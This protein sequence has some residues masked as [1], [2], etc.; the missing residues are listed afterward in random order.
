MFSREKLVTLIKEGRPLPEIIRVA[1]K[2]IIDEALVIEAQRF[3]DEHQESL[4]DGRSR[5]V[6]NGTANE[7]QILFPFGSVPVKAPRIL[8]RKAGEDGLKFTSKALPRYLRKS[9]DLVELIPWLYLKGLS[10]NDFKSVFEAIYGQPVHGFSPA[11][12]SGHVEGWVKE[13]VAW[14]S[15]DMTRETYAYV[16]ADGVYFKV[17]G[18]RDNVCQLVLLGVDARGCKRLVGMAEGYAESSDSW[19]EL[20]VK[21][22]SQGLEGP[23]LV[24]GDGG[25]GL[26]SALS[27][28]YPDSAKQFCWAHK[29]K[30]VQRYLPK[31]RHREVIREV[32]DIYLSEKKE[33][34]T[35]KI[36]RLGAMFEVKHVQAAETLTRHI[37][38]L[39]AFYDF[40]SRHWIHIRTNNPIESLFSTVRLRTGKTRGSLGRERLGALVFKLGQM[41]SA[42]MRAITH[43]QMLEALLSGRK[44]KDGLELEE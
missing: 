13:Y 26:W 39:L 38:E 15:R 40:P 12:I 4:E 32:R 6:L 14:S 23:K 43:A 44:Y 35:K 37:E 7:R 34:A 33:E 28:V 17:K 11:T 9:Q 31:S 30:D 19:R 41:A 36:K 1:T 24:V 42:N 27:R 5:L 2:D 22:K 16:W 8:D 3:I 25:L 20:F 21:L 10:V 29:I 18:E